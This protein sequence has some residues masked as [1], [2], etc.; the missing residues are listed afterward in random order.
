MLGSINIKI[1]SGRVDPF[2][3]N[4]FKTRLFEKGTAQIMHM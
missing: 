3:D 2:L 1:D 4:T